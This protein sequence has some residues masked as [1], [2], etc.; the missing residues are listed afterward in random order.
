VLKDAQ[1]SL[2][3]VAGGD[4]DLRQ[5]LTDGKVKQV[6]PVSSG[7]PPVF[8][9][10]GSC[11]N[12]SPEHVHSRQAGPFSAVARTQS[13]TTLNGTLA[14]VFDITSDKRHFLSTVAKHGDTVIGLVVGAPTSAWA[15]DGDDLR[16][17]QETFKL[18]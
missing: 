4:P 11:A 8:S 7:C 17:I 13:Q 12:L 14:Y 18:L 3:V 10:V 15:K 9:P 16:H 1:T 6:C 5:A 2:I